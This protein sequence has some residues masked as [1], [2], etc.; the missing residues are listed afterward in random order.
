MSSRLNRPI[1]VFFSYSHR[2]IRL[3]EK[4]RDHLSALERQ[5]MITG[6]H[7]RKIIPGA[8]WEPEI[9]EYLNA[10]EIV[11]LLVSPSFMASNYSNEIE[12]RRAMERH[13]A[14]EARVI[15]VLLHPVT[16]EGAPFS[17]LQA[18]PEN[19]KPV[20][21]WRNR[22]QALMNIAEGIKKVAK[23]MNEAQRKSNELPLDYFYI[24]HTS[25]LR[26][27]KQEEFRRLTNLNIDHYDI[28][29]VI[30]SSY[31]G[32][33]D[34]V[35][36]VKYILDDSY[37][38]PIYEFSDEAKS[39]KFLLKELANGEYVLKAEVYLKDRSEPVYLQRFITLW[40]SGPELA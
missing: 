31:E 38:T 11:L 35:R 5:G 25:F 24:N 6:W 36:R 40:K 23:A 39:S 32:A 29:V 13:E 20:T 4:L 27:E 1:K 26:K 14:K 21:L 30:D 22:D 16:W 10:A 34:K 17:K 33:L 9:D 2:D 3:V 7:D 37:P 18:L 28:R 12:V 15:P 19:A 8:E